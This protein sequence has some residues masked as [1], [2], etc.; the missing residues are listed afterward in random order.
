MGEGADKYK[1][2]VKGETDEEQVEVAI[3]AFAHTV[4]DPGAVVVKPLDAV[5]ADAAVR[6]TGRPEYLAGETELQLHRLALHLDSQPLITI[7]PVLNGRVVAGGKRC[8]CAGSTPEAAGG[9]ATL[10]GVGR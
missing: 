2:A 6:G 5:V 7:N 1:D 8:C 9:D 3:I 4:A 10:A